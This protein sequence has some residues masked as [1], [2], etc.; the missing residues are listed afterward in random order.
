M[1]MRQSVNKA[2][3]TS[4]SAMMLATSIGANVPSMTSF[5]SEISRSNTVVSGKAST[6][7]ELKD[8]YLEVINGIRDKDHLRENTNY[9]S[10]KNLIE[11]IEAL[12]QEERDKLQDLWHVAFDSIS[13][14][15]IASEAPDFEE[16][17][18]YDEA[19]KLAFKT[20]YVQNKY[21]AGISSP[22]MQMAFRFKDSMTRFNHIEHEIDW[23]K[24]D[25]YRNMRDTMRH[26]ASVAPKS[27][28]LFTNEFKTED[29]EDVAKAV[30]N[31]RNNHTGILAV[32]IRDLKLSDAVLVDAMEEAW[33]TMPAKAKEQ[34][35]K[36]SESVT[37]HINKMAELKKPYM[38]DEVLHLK[39]AY[40]NLMKKDVSD[41]TKADKSE[42][43]QALKEADALYE[44]GGPYRF[45]TENEKRILDTFAARIRVLEGA[46]DPTISDSDKAAVDEFRK[47]HKEILSKSADKIKM[48]DLDAAANAY[49]DYKSKPQPVRTLLD[50]EFENLT[51]MM[52][53][54]REFNDYL[55]ANNSICH[56]SYDAITRADLPL[57]DKAINDYVHLTKTVKAMLLDKHSEIL[58]FRNKIYKDIHTDDVVDVAKKSIDNV[59]KIKESDVKASDLAALENANYILSTYE[60]DIQNRLAKEQAYINKLMEK[61]KE[62]NKKLEDTKMN[63]NKDIT[64]PNDSVTPTPKPDENVT[65]DSSDKTEKVVDTHISISEFEKKHADIIDKTENTVK[66]EDKKKISDAIEDYHR[67][68]NDD[69]GRK[70]DVYMHLKK[71]EE[72]VD[73]E[74]NNVKDLSNLPKSD[75]ESVNNYRSKHKDT[76]N[77]NPDNVTIRDEKAI[78]DARD[79]YDKLSIL[80]KIKAAEDAKRLNALEDALEKI[81]NKTPYMKMTYDAYL[82]LYGVLLKRDINSLKLDDYDAVYKAWMDYNELSVIDQIRLYTEGYRVENF[83]QEMNFQRKNGVNSNPAYKDIERPWLKDPVPEDAYVDET[84]KQNEYYRKL[85]ENDPKEQPKLNEEDY[86]KKFD[87]SSAGGVNAPNSNVNNAPNKDGKITNSTST[88]KNDKAIEKTMTFEEYLKKYS[89]ILNK[90]PSEITNSD[91]DI[92]KKARADIDKV[93]IVTNKDKKSYDIIVKSLDE[94]LKK[95]GV[96]NRDL[97]KETPKNIDK[98]KSS[99]NTSKPDNKTNNKNDNKT[100]NKNN[101]VDKIDN[102]TDNKNENKSTDIKNEETKPNIETGNVTENKVNDI[103]K[104]QSQ[105]TEI[106]SI[107]SFRNKY[108]KLLNMKMKD[109]KLSDLDEV[110]RALNDFEK[111]SDADKEKYKVIQ[112]NL[113]IVKTR[114]ED[115][116]KNGK[117]VYVKNPKVGVIQTNDNANV[118]TFKEQFKKLW[119]LD[120]K[121]GSKISREYSKML[122]QAFDM[123]NKLNESDRK[124]LFLEKA[125][126]D[127]LKQ[128]ID[129]EN[130]PK[131]DPANDK[132]YD[133]VGAGIGNTNSTSNNVGSS[134]DS[135]KE[136]SKTDAKPDTGSMNIVYAG[137]GSSISA[138]IGGIA[139]CLNKK[140]RKK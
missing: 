117:K 15:P 121:D 16:E 60:E 5:A 53:Y 124:S 129:D 46:N 47:K 35:K 99:N 84:T 90:K 38:T 102:K 20:W 82:K 81:K 113:T 56:K 116:K 123:Y 29:D 98:N 139:L 9:E 19:T 91:L 77:I 115:E 8:K 51:A 42:V 32:D 100:D 33:N 125:H 17:D 40:K 132:K 112:Q 86:S 107:E 41:I 28:T 88:D 25:T 7:K 26:L 62:L 68:S 57:I 21:Y 30:I 134:G 11:A 126:M 3:A 10:V 122:K 78:K 24:E 65:T 27:P 23:E 133:S 95:L 31:F 43:M 55:Q 48:N 96:D 87:G 110:S 109:V 45:L 36:Y 52:A 6:A 4:L 49:N 131:I 50:K 114:L 106:M 120:G 103:I 108:T 14:I 111:L 119:K 1:K 140:F 64:E 34:L 69:K 89:D 97:N 138:L 61:A 104:N 75:S 74:I 58:T 37:A 63:P 136:P 83:M 22:K 13:Y 101:N 66:K 127:R 118:A 73:G 72:K 18:K 12:P 105:T 92:L 71:L 137:A 130:S 70:S 79:D 44:K 39:N 59:L 67:L 54:A 135:E 80:D 93:K 128:L 85:H 76:L 2:V 94:N